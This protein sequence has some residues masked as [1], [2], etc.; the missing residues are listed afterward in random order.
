MSRVSFSMS[1]VSLGQERSG[2]SILWLVTQETSVRKGKEIR[3]ENEREKTKEKKKKAAKEG[4][5]SVMHEQEL[6]EPPVRN[7]I[8][9][10]FHSLIWFLALCYQTSLSLQQPI[11]VS[12]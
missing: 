8:P 12:T 7:A 1:G 4:E 10:A 5:K 11:L 6:S 9:T 3:G 2:G